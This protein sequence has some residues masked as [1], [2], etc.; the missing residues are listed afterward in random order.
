MHKLNLI[1]A[2]KKQL[3]QSYMP[4]VLQ[5]G[6]FIPTNDELELDQTVDLNLELIGAKYQV[7][8]KVVWKTPPAV[9]GRTRPAGVGVQFS[10]DQEKIRNEIETQL[11]GYSPSDVERFTF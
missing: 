10:M 9:V 6:L 3:Y 1:I 11:A 7:V 8:S 4:F 2:D 5:G